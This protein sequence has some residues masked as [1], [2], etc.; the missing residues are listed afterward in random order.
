MILPND[1]CGREEIDGAPIMDGSD[2]S[3]VEI[4]VSDGPEMLI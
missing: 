3:Y 1:F 4:V 2:S